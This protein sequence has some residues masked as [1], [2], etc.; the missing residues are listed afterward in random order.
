MEKE[1]SFDQFCKEHDQLLHDPNY[2]YFS[3]LKNGYPEESFTLEE[4]IQLKGVKIYVFDGD[5]DEPAVIFD[6]DTVEPSIKRLSEFQELDENYGGLY[7]EYKAAG[8]E[9]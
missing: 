1:I 3:P 9:F 5:G 2:K 8:G 6:Y 4:S 7:C